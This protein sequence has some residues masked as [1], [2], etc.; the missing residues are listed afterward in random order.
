MTKTKHTPG[1]WQVTESDYAVGK[2]EGGQIYG[3]GA[4]GVE[5][6]DQKIH[7]GETPLLVATVTGIDT[8]VFPHLGCAEANA[9]LI[10][11]APLMLDALKRVRIEIMAINPPCSCVGKQA[12]PACEILFVT[13]EAIDQAEGGQ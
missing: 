6:V 4:F 3:F 2:F 13:K 7:E 8:H 5:T 10:A 1:P 11:A 9:R 12:C